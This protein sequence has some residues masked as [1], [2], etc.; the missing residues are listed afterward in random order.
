ML[1]AKVIGYTVY[2]AVL[3]AVF[4]P[5]MLTGESDLQKQYNIIQSEHLIYGSLVTQSCP[6]PRI[7]A[8]VKI[9]GN[10]LAVKYHTTYAT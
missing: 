6:E 3:A 4:L 9:L 5:I 7:F 10:N 2:M 1:M 8:S